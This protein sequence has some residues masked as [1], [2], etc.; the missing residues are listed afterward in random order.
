MASKPR[1]SKEC[2]ASL[3]YIVNSLFPKKIRKEKKRKRE[4]GAVSE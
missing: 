4:A 2:K 3:I 1:L